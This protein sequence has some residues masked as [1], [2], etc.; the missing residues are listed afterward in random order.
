MPLEFLTPYDNHNKSQLEYLC[1]D[2]NI[3]HYSQST[4]SCCICLLARP[5][6]LDNRVFC[7]RLWREE[8]T[9]H[10]HSQTG[11]LCRKL[12]LEELEYFLGVN[13]HVCIIKETNNL[14]QFNSSLPSEHSALP[15]QWKCPGMQDLSLHWNWS[16]RQVMFW[17]LGI[18]S[19]S[20]F[21]QSGSPFIIK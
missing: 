16:A 11:F 14:L 12:S 7:H 19:S 15:E 4:H 10:H 13:K 20:L 3:L 21:G 9:F 5:E 1:K 6:T 18:F 2:A 8:C 17:Q